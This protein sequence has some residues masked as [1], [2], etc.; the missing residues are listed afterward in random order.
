MLVYICRCLC[1]ALNHWLIW[2]GYWNEYQT[3][4]K[5]LKRIFL[6]FGII[7]AADFIKSIFNQNAIAHALS[8]LS[9]FSERILI[10]FFL[11]F[12]IYAQLTKVNGLNTGEAVIFIFIDCSLPCVQIGVPIAFYSMTSKINIEPHHY[13]I[14]VNLNKYRV[15]QLR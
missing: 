13:T 15:K 11:Y 2:I 5:T 6:L 10:L 1:L 8:V 3:Y 4:E 9:Y 7:M 14:L 12:A